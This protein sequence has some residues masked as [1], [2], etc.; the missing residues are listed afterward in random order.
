MFLTVFNRFRFF[1]V[2]GFCLSG[3]LVFAGNVSL[4]S[5]FC[6]VT[7]SRVESTG[8]VFSFEKKVYILGS[9]EMTFNGKA[10]P[11]CHFVRVNEM[12]RPIK[13]VKSDWGY[14]VALFDANDVVGLEPSS[15][16]AGAIG[17][18]QPILFGLQ[19][20]VILSTRS[21]RHF[22]GSHETVLEA[23]RLQV[24]QR[25][26]GSPVY[27]KMRPTEIV[28]FI[29]SQFLEDQGALGTFIRSWQSKAQQETQ[30]KVILLGAERIL[31]WVAKAHAGETAADYSLDLEAQLRGEQKVNFAFLQ[32][33]SVCQ[34][35]SSGAASGDF[36]VA[37]R[38]GGV[39]GFG[40]GGDSAADQMCSIQV[41]RNPT[42]FE[43]TAKST[44]YA[45]RNAW[46][47]NLEEVMRQQKDPL[48]LIL[49]YYRDE[50]GKIVSA[51]PFQSLGQFFKR[52]SDP[53]YQFV[54][55]TGTDFDFTFRQPLTALDQKQTFY[56]FGGAI[57]KDYKAVPPASEN[58]LD[59]LNALAENAKRLRNGIRSAPFDVSKKMFG[60][61]A[62]LVASIL[63]GPFWRDVRVE[64]LDDLLKD[65]PFLGFDEYLNK[66]KGLRHDLD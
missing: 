29:S 63:E 47:L 42:T 60:V 64:D 48:S 53:K 4:V 46:L 28:G 51:G 41:R 20:G 35:I 24:N 1:A 59:R 39:D 65:S 45:F 61:R 17:I 52:L 13:L 31:Q 43:L 34:K 33:S 30:K 25:D 19:Q 21:Q 50:A 44:S 37:T 55:R 18:A 32:F 5:Q 22:F 49:S 54:V 15:L 10:S 2:L 7:T 62:Y 40:I 57:P 12:D 26:V 36:P 14:G 8:F 6:S 56:Y 58:Q 16:T 9:A 66:M 11:I 3:S 27:S 23:G 38:Q